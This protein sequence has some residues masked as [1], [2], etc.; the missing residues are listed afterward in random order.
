MNQVE[1]KSKEGDLNDVMLSGPMS[2]G[3]HFDNSR[4]G[5]YIVVNPSGSRNWV[6]R[7]VVNK[8]RREIGLGGFPTIDTKAARNFARG[9]K[10]MAK[11]GGDPIAMKRQEDGL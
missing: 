7:V 8:K 3:K 10:E 5:L 4:L 2:V 6:Q 1:I 11:R 9:N